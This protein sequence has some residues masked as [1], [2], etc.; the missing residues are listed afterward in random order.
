MTAGDHIPGPAVIEQS[1]TTTLVPP[2][3]SA[4]AVDGGN[5]SITREK[6]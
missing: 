1:D 6:E 5:L 2:G 3:W 4:I